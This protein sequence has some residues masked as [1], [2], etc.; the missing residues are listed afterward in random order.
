MRELQSQELPFWLRV[1]VFITYQVGYVFLLMTGSLLACV[2]GRSLEGDLLKVMTAGFIFGFL[3]IIQEWPIRCFALIFME[4]SPLKTQRFVAYR[5]LGSMWRHIKVSWWRI[6]LTGFLAGTT[7][8]SSTLFFG[9]PLGAWYTLLVVVDTILVTLVSFRLLVS[10][11][12]VR[13]L[14]ENGL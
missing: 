7:M 14:R 9:P 1:P 12:I 5:P 4:S 11:V 6:F 13:E 2:V 3:A 8:M 10:P